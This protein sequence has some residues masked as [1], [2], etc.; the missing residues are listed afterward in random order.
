MMSSSLIEIIDTQQFNH[1]Q[2][3][4]VYLIRGDCPVLIESGTA[5]SSERTIAALSNLEDCAPA[6]IFLT[7]VH[8]DHA[9]GA[10]HLAR[11]FP[12]TKIVVH[13]R[14]AQHLADTRQLLA[15]VRA[16][17]PELFPQYGEPLPVPEHQL[18]TVAGGEVFDLGKNVQLQVIAAP[19]H[20]P[21]H[22]CFHEQVSRTLFTGD[23][24]GNWNN[25]VDVPLTVP[26]RFDIP[27]GLESLQSL[28]LL[29]LEYLAFTH[30]GITSNALNHLQRYERQLI[31]WIDEI[32]KLATSLEPA[33]IAKHIL[34]RPCYSGLS[35]TERNLIAM[36]VVG[37][38][39]SLHTARE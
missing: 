24:V 10:G 20:A 18:V 16:A 4:A 39:L 25:P 35:E 9:G 34:D 22:V 13:E 19:G 32:G 27:R 3:G 38:T 21:H 5:A 2:S 28:Q 37:A 29:D 6:F 15:S 12:N 17:A 11:A 36:C 26:P 30:F 23:A 14:G 8:L 1:P 7:H 31:E 33:D